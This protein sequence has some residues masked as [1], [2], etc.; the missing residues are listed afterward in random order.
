M[1]KYTETELNE[2]NFVR[3]SLIC[4]QIKLTSHNNIHSTAPSFL[5]EINKI[6]FTWLQYQIYKY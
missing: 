1:D 6:F 3:Y 2:K 5:D 4:P